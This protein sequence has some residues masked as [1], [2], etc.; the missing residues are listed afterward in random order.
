MDIVR[1]ELDDDLKKIINGKDNFCKVVKMFYDGI[2]RDMSAGVFTPPISGEY[3]GKIVINC[4]QAF[5]WAMR[6]TCSFSP[7][8]LENMAKNIQ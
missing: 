3:A 6:K 1:I 5:R 2:V 4:P 7:K 8:S